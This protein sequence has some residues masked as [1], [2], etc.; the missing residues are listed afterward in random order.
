MRNASSILGS[1]VLACALA[2]SACGSSGGVITPGGDDQTNIQTRFIDSVDGEVIEFGAG[3]FTL[4][5]PLELSNREGIVLR[6]QGMDETILDFSGQETGGAGLDLM[7][8]TNVVIEDMR[9]MDAAGNGLRISNSDGVV[10]RR[11]H[12]GWTA[13]DNVENGKYAIYPVSSDNVL[14]EDC[15]AENASDAGLYIG[16]VNTCIVRNSEAY[17]NVAG[18]EIENSNDCEVYGN[19]AENNTG[20][21]LVFELPNLPNVGSGTLVFDNVI[22]N[23]NRPNFG[24]PTT[25]VGLVP[26]GTGL[27]ILAANDIEIRDNTIEGN[28]GTAVAVVAYPV[29]TALSGGSVDDE[30]YEQFN[31]D[32]WV[33]DNTFANNGQ[34][35]GGTTATGANDTLTTLAGLMAA[36]GTEL[37][38]LEDIVF[39]GFARPDQEPSDVL[40]VSNN[41]DATFRLLDVPGLLADELMSNTDATPHDC[42]GTAR[43]RVDESFADFADAAPEPTE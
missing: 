30:D 7:N 28:E 42:T 39:D 27:F 35:P 1:S 14:V 19:T 23:N 34:M 16:Q 11:V 31:D 21:V 20:G 6:G 13:E 26:R 10:I 18:I 40:C 36:A 38:T 24:D 9:I 8:M 12:A 41:G 32:I 29:V 17:G 5:D 37:T 3:T 43:P 4:T 33:H 15:V 2:L 22:R 25:T